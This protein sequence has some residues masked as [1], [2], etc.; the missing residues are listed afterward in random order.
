[1]SGA[2]TTGLGVLWLGIG[3]FLA[4]VKVFELEEDLLPGLGMAM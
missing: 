3:H 4:R 1:M 2:L